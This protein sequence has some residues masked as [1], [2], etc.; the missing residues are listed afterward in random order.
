VNQ[1]IFS[2]KKEIQMFSGIG[3]IGNNGIILMPV[4]NPSCSN[5]LIA[6][7]RD[8]G[9]GAPGSLATSFCVNERDQALL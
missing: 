2:L 6:S 7:T 5:F 1:G 9:G 3:E 4:Q 8:E